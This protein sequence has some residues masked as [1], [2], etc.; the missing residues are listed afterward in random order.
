MR[1]FALL[2]S[3]FILSANFL[4]ASNQKT[5]PL[6]KVTLQLQWKYQ[7]QFAGFIMAKELGYYE[8]EGLDVEI[9]EYDNSNTIQ[10]L[11]DSKIDYAI[12]NSSLIYKDKKL[13]NVT[14]LA[15]YFQRSPLIL[16]TQPE[17]KSPLG[18]LGKKLMMSKNNIGYVHVKGWQIICLLATMPSRRSA[19]RFF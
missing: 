3:L 2:F 16:I 14:L 7:F 9:L 18:L 15:T 13:Q 12:N 19:E 10:K 8:D 1:F 5:E 6:E 11:I 17:I 4:N